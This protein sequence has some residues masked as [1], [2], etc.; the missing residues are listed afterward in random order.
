LNI[1]SNELEKQEIAALAKDIKQDAT[2]L[3]QTK[4]ESS[5]ERT[6]N[7]DKAKSDQSDQSANNEEI[8]IDKEGNIVQNSAPKATPQN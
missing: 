7:E 6:S 2:N 1:S 4:S 5:S 8:F 3:S